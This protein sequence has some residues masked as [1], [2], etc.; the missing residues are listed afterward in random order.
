MAYVYT[1]TRIDTEV[2]FYVG[3]GKKPKYYRAFEKAKRG[4]H[5][6][7]IT[8]KSD[9]VTRIELDN[10]TWQDAQLKERGLISLY[11]RLD[12]G[13]GTLCNRTNGGEGSNGAIVSE[14]T[15]RKISVAK[16]GKKRPPDYKRS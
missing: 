2:V 12:L 7:N 4:K 1:H 14:E 6:N 3:I 13:T 11:G 15:K 8:A 16:T 10:C 5:W 9:F